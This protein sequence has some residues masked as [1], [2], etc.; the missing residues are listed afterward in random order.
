MMNCRRHLEED[1][2]RCR[3]ELF[4]LFQEVLSGG[5]LVG[6]SVEKARAVQ[7]GCVCFVPSVVL[8]SRQ[9]Q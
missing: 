9:R 1:C 7:R 4:D 2:A 3:R 5:I 8:C 6:H